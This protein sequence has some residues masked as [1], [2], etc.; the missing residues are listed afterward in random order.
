MTVYTDICF[1]TSMHSRVKRIMDVRKQ[2]EGKVNIVLQLSL[3]MCESVV[4]EFS[5][6]EEKA[7]ENQGK[8]I[9]PSL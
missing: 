5:S 3:A 2:R 9:G 8:R 4:L 1:N 7:V 6:N